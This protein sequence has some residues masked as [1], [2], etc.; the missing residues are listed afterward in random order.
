MKKFLLFPVLVLTLLLAGCSAEKEINTNVVLPTADYSDQMSK[1]KIVPDKIE[2]FLFHSTQ[3]CTTCIAI[4][5]LAGETVNEYF[6]PELKSG[7]I[8]FRAIN[9]D[10]PENRE[11]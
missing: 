9:I 5:R 8:E 6:Q 10:L 1:V 2:V 7:K 3:R 4:G 11:S